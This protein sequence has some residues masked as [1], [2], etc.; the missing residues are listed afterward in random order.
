MPS[1][2]STEEVLAV[3]KMNDDRCEP[4]SASEVADKLPYEYHRNTARN[5]LEDLVGLGDLET[6]KVGPS[7]VYWR[8]CYSSEGGSSGEH[9]DTE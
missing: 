1:D 2:L 5:Y 3:F 4:F 6:K 9:L 7:R 8:P